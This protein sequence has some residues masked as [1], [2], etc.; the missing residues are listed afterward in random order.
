[1]IDL[2]K[3]AGSAASNIG[4]VAS[5]IASSLGGSAANLMSSIR[6]ASIPKDNITPK[7]I[8]D[9][10]AGSGGD[11]S[12]WR[13]RLSFPNN[14][15]EFQDNIFNPLKE[16]GGL[17]FPYTPTISINAIAN[18]NESPVTHQNYQFISY[19]N[20]RT[21]EI[22]ISGEFFVE[23]A[24][25]AQYWLSAV[26]FLRSVTKMFVGSDK[27]A[28]NP[29]ILLYFNA[30]GD[31]VFRD[32]P[33]VVKSFSMT[34]PKEVDYIITNI[35]GK[36][37]RSGGNF[38]ADTPGGVSNTTNQLAGVLSAAGATNAANLIRNVN[39]I[40]KLLAGGANGS[41]IS[42]R[43][44][45]ASNLSDENDSHVPTQSTLNLTLLP[46]YS[47]TRVR[48]FSLEQFIKGGYVKDGFI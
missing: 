10:Q 35:S 32:V 20:S 33:V 34:L 4:K 12:D 22:S 48:K 9:V 41:K 46:I 44:L 14:V 37:G 24:I 7:D 31:F 8:P 5:G 27:R 2:A 16:A 18:Y 47:R 26:H 36:E 11:S 1:M 23:D 21:S 19:A 29:P 3:I 6:S 25:Q 40:G 17:I 42:S 28:G 30:Y 38:G 43:F 39:N 15:E 13:V 45:S